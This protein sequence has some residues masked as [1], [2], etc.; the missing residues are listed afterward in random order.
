MKIL[1]TATYKHEEVIDTDDP[2]FQDYVNKEKQY[3]HNDK[4]TLFDYARRYAQR[5]WWWSHSN[6]ETGESQFTDSY[7]EWTTIEEK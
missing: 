3:K 2:F 7:L 5:S 1:I 6:D 4:N